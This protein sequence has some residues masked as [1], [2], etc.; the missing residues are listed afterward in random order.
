MRPIPAA[1]LPL[2][3]DPA[4][5]ADCVIRSEFAQTPKSRHKAGYTVLRSVLFPFK[6]IIFMIHVFVLTV[7]LMTIIGASGIWWGV[8]HQ[9]EANE[10]TAATLEY[11]DKNKDLLK[12]AT[13]FMSHVFD[14]MLPSKVRP[15]P[16]E[17]EDPPRMSLR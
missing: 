10:I 17:P 11:I 9:K 16:V 15:V 6:I 1:R 2:R 13:D 4:Q 12:P 3:P 5:Q 7:G 8:N 14:G